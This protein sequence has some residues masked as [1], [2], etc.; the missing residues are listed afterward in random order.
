MTIEAN[1][2][3]R[4]TLLDLTCRLVRLPSDASNVQARKAALDVILS[5][6][7]DAVGK[8]AYVLSETVAQSSDPGQAVT[9][10]HVKPT[11]RHSGPTVLL[12]GHVDVVAPTTAGQFEP[13]L[14]A[15]RLYGRGAG[16]MKGGVAVAAKLFA[17]FSGTRNLQLLL[18]SDEE[19][20]GQAGAK[21][22]A[23]NLSPD[24]V[25]ALEPTNMTIRLREKGGVLLDVRATGP[26]GHAARP[27]LAESAVDLLLDVYRRLRLRYPTLDHER[28]DN[29]MNL[30]AIAGGNLTWDESTGPKLGIGNAIAASAGLCLDFRLTE[31]S[32]IDDVRNTTRLAAEE[33]MAALVAS[34]S[35]RGMSSDAYSIEV[36][37][38]RVSVEHLVTDGE[39]QLVRKLAGSLT[40][41][42]GRA[43]QFG[44]GPA[45]SDARFFSAR[46]VPSVVF[47][48]TSVNHHG[49]NEYLETKTLVEL[50]N[51]LADFFAGL[52]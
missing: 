21:L 27:W 4:E 23:P 34:L 37:D 22:V 38:P 7:D 11:T 40:S 32:S 52:T 47:G 46:G 33:T 15:G 18:T 36:S 19:R 10:C 25:I 50:Y 2:E 8:G 12:L 6:L 1:S 13:R 16:D 5:F 3:L 29:T 43:A 44:D 17:E 41:V 51:V 49:A 24:L 28:W 31:T 35:R 30:G 39:H 45:A 26:G 48:P 9:T 42:L 20:G 14:E